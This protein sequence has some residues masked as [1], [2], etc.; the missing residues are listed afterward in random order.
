VPLTSHAPEPESDDALMARVA[1]RD[2]VAFR[3]LIDAYGAK[4]QRI[5]W[6]M[7]GDKAEAEDIAQEALLRL[8][9][10]AARWKGGGPGVGAWLTRVAMN[11]CLDKL[12]R[13]KF[14]SDEEIPERADES[15][16]ADDVIDEARARQAVISAVQ[17]LPDNQRAAI[18][19]TYYEDVSN[20]MA[21]QTLDMNIK[22]FESLLLRARQ[23]LRKTLAITGDDAS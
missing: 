11:L 2:A 19:L 17:A 4:A 5:G 8:W 21:A 1:A 16:G 20:I 7:L 3:I 12:R 15:P 10:H 13:R 6:R 22:A 9:D 18:T 14:S 23:A